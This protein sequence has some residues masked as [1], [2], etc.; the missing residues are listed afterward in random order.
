MH[1]VVTPNTP[2]MSYWEPHNFV[3]FLRR[4]AFAEASFFLYAQQQFLPM[5]TAFPHRTYKIESLIIIETSLSEQKIIL[6]TTESRSTYSNRKS[7]QTYD[8]IL[9]LQKLGAVSYQ[10]KW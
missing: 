3:K 7:V 6:L 1:S 8:S 2:P 10:A 5:T 9:L 4:L